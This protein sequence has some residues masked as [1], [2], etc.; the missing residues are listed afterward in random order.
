MKLLM[1]G[2]VVGRPGRRAVTEIVPRL[3]DELHLD[4][5]IANGE[6]AAAGFGLTR[7][8]LAELL[9][10]GVDCLTSGNHIWA[11]REIYELLNSEARLLRPANYPAGA[12]GGGA[13]VYPLPGGGSVG[14]LNL[15]GRVFMNALDHPFARAEQELA[16]LRR[17]TPLLV[18]DFHAEA[19]SEK[20]AFGRCFDGRVSA[21]LGT[22]THVQT[23]DEC[24]LPRGTAY[25]TDCGMTGPVDSVIG[26]EVQ[27][28]IDFY[29]EQLPHRFQVAGGDALLCGVVLELDDHTG[30]ATSIERIREV[31]RS[32]TKSDA[33]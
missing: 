8:T 4:F 7:R 10:S 3:R 21:V 30:R 18:V 2:D 9:D 31:S 23:A 27:T 15:C 14:V 32:S 19:T 29:R 33:E 24:I 16:A 13:A 20:I 26:T 25:I 5:V 22:H 6:N 12:P 28:V 1:V 17:T 11:K